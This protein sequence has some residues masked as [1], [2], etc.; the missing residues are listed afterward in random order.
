[1]QTVLALGKMHCSVEFALVLDVTNVGWEC[2][3]SITLENDLF[4]HPFF[5]KKDIQM[6]WLVC[7]LINIY[8][9]ICYFFF[10]YISSLRI[11][12]IMHYCAVYNYF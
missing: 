6:L 7:C 3:A 12:C 11:M 1:M 2:G 5:V 8:I 9:N 4:L 10:I